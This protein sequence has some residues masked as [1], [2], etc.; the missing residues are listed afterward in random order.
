M[1]IKEHYDEI[2]EVLDQTF[3]FI[4]EGLA[5]HCEKVNL[6]WI[7]GLLAGWYIAFFQWSPQQSFLFALCFSESFEMTCLGSV[8]ANG[9]IIMF[10]CARRFQ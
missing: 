7:Q 3:Q 2:L 10:L 8:R 9:E 6:R 1:T 5:Q 4:F